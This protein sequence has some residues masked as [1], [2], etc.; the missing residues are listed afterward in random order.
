MLYPKTK[1]LSEEEMKI[2]CDEYR[3]NNH[4]DLAM[5][6]KYGVKRGL[7]N[8]DGTGVLAGLTSICDAQGYERGEDGSVIPKEGRL[9][10][11]GYALKDLCKEAVEQD[12]FMFEEVLYLLLVGKK[13]TRIEF[14]MFKQM[15]TN[16]R[17]LPDGFAETM[18]FGAP[19]PNIMNKMT[20]SVLAMYSYDENAEDL[21]LEN[22]LSQSINL[23][24][25]L[26]T[27]MVYAYQVYRHVYQHQSMYFHFPIEGLS[28]AEH[29]LATLRGN[30]SYTHE[31][32]KLLDLALMCYADHGG[33]NSSTF[34]DRVVSSV[35]TDTYSAIAAA[36][37]AL[38][39]SKL[40]GANI[41]VMRQLD[42]LMRS[43]V[44]PD[45]DASVKRALKAILNREMGDGSGLIYG[46][47][48]VI[49]TLSDPRAV[50]LRDN[51]A[52]LARKLGHG[53]EY[54]MLRM[55]EKLAP[56][57][58]REEM[59]VTKPMCAN[60]DLYSGI[61]FRILGIE[62][63]LYAP[64]FAIA[65]IGGWCA[66]RMEELAF[67]NRVIRPAYKY[68]GPENLKIKDQ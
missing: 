17:E 13:P 47:G 58:L 28:T 57:C 36:L 33:G 55:I 62:E 6:E 52:E 19:S 53:K 22:V 43:G 41:K 59:G 54:D 10:Y 14:E 39:G 42:E 11:R 46:I 7:R 25:Q 4:I 44:N 40:G 49:Y 12:R 27:M 32:A 8:D 56:E 21:S 45:S 63:R 50:V 3:E 48:H 35:G 38:K 34:A 24:A 67:N 65:R 60:I 2:F 64:V 26:P 15:I 37:S 9:L 30:Q 31:E 66:H 20:R 1:P 51:S 23:I 29:V 68:V 16:H 5:C 18:I 61:V